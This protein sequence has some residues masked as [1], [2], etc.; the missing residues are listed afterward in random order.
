METE[1]TEGSRLKRDLGN[2]TSIFGT[3]FWFVYKGKEDVLY[4]SQ[5]SN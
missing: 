1:K 5:I 2:K 3:E 4:E